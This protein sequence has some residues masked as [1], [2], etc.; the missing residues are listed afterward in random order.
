[1]NSSRQGNGPRR[2]PGW[3]AVLAGAIVA[4]QAMAVRGQA[5]APAATA[6]TATAPAASQP[7]GETIDGLME[8]A[9]KALQAKQFE[10][11][12]VYFTRILKLE[13]KNIQALAGMA[14]VFTN[15]KNPAEAFRYGLDGAEAA[16]EA[17]QYAAAE[18]LLLDA[19]A[20]DPTN[21][22]VFL[23]L[24]AVYLATNREM[25][26]IEVYRRYQKTET[27]RGDY[28][29]YLAIGKQY[30]ANRYYRQAIASLKRADELNPRDAET[31]RALAWAHHAAREFDAAAKAAAA[32]LSVSPDDLE[33]AATY[34]AI[35]SEDPTSDEKKQ[36][37]QLNLARET[38]TRALQAARRRFEAKP[39]DPKLLDAMAKS[40]RTLDSVLQRI[41]ARDR[42]KTDPAVILERARALQ[43][44]AAIE[45]AMQLY[46]ALDLLDA[47]VKLWPRNVSVLRELASVQ[48][49]VKKT[50]AAADTCRAILDI[51]PDDAFAKNLLRQLGPAS[52]QPQARP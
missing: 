52:T 21:P 14:A 29:G 18:Q 49:Q 31:L 45:H 12:Q 34:A 47:A 22:R 17:K 15:L 4:A 10:A 50:A 28:R 40:C 1:M 39:D 16:I 33:S 42:A 25:K 46:K 32:A 2:R 11:A 41:A 26:A 30:Y 36:L 20:M 23:G 27:G 9:R 13:P 24:G 7:E 6:P 51:S 38:L 48:S 37:E 43:E 19:Q 3:G 44:A 35:V 8:A 5:T